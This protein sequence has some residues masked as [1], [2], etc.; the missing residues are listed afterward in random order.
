M[1]EKEQVKEEKEQVKEE[2]EQENEEEQVKEEE[3]EEE[4]E[5]LEKILYKGV[6]YY[7]DSQRFIYSITHDEPSNDPVGYWKEKSKSITFY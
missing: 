1:G 5:E 2:K 4:E 3:E 6:A 7:R